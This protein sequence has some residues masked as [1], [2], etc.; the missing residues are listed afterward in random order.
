[1]TEERRG[2]D[3]MVDEVLRMVSEG[4]LTAEEADAM[5]GALDAHRRGPREMPVPGGPFPE[6]GPMRRDE[7]NRRRHARIE[8]MERGRSVVNLKI[9]IVPFSLGRYALSHVPG[10]SDV[11]AERITDAIERGLTG[12]ILEVEDDDGDSVRIVV[13]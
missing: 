2:S 5:L 8:V 11:N 13:E 12:P 4:R 1:M 10:L 7:P 3:D 9:P 6:K